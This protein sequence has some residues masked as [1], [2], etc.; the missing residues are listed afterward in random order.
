MN[1]EERFDTVSERNY[2]SPHETV[3][4]QFK[5]IIL[6]EGVRLSEPSFVWMQ[7]RPTSRGFCLPG[8]LFAEVAELAD[9]AVLKTAGKPWGFDSPLPHQA[10]SW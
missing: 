5:P 3:I 8:F 1:A 9:A 6:R 10:G 7:P 4:A 2:A